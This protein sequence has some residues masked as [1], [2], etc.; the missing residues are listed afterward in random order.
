MRRH[1]FLLYTLG[2][3][4]LLCTIYLY[5]AIT[6]GTRDSCSGLGGAQRALCQVG[7]K[8]GKANTHKSH[9][10][11]LMFVSEEDSGTSVLL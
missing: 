6:L 11:R 8:A 3:L 9:L 10:R 5:F 2:L 7:V 1:K 4:T